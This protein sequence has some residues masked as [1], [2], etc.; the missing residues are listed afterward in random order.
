MEIRI[1]TENDLHTST[2]RGSI[3]EILLT[4]VLNISEC[5]KA[6][7]PNKKI[8]RITNDSK[9]NIIDGVE[10]MLYKGYYLVVE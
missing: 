5:H 2:F 4:K 9:F 1:R 6:K 7:D 3:A 8:F 10:V